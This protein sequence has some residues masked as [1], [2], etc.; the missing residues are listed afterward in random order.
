MDIKVNAA[1]WT[2]LGNDERDR[3]ES[4]VKGFFKTARIV[5]DPYVPTSIPPMAALAVTM[6]TPQIAALAA[7]TNPWCIAACNVA[8]AAAVAACASLINPI[9]IAACI[10]AAHEA[11][12]LCRGQC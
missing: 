8:E 11:G 2:G 1:E 5:P 3:I 6:S 12:N 9:A 10:A 4:I 7:G